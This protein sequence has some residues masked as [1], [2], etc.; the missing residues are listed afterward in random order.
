M[1]K[2][3][4]ET[5]PFTDCN[6]QIGYIEINELAK[7]VELVITQKINGIINCCS[8]TFVPT[9]EQVEMFIKKIT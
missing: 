1:A 6:N 2:A 9:K 7:Q 4:R 5:F 8:G 3:G